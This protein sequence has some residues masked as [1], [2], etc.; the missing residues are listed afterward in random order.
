MALNC[1]QERSE[2]TAGSLLNRYFWMDLDSEEVVQ[3][4]NCKPWTRIAVQK[5]VWTE[6]QNFSFLQV[7]QTLHPPYFPMAEFISQGPSD[8]VSNAVTQTHTAEKL[9]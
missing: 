8:L 4:L 3:E 6:L 7:F 5:Q 9:Q 2:G 1:H